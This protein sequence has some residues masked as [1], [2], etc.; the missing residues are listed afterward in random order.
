LKGLKRIYIE[1]AILFVSR[2][3]ETL[4]LVFYVN[5]FLTIIQTLQKILCISGLFNEQ[6][7]I[8][9]A[10]MLKM[11]K[12]SDFCLVLSEIMKKYKIQ[13]RP[14]KKTA[15]EF[16]EILCAFSHPCLLFSLGDELN[17]DYRSLVEI[18][19]ECCECKKFL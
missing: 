19:K 4:Q 18:R 1:Y 14:F 15:N 7:T 9:K 6:S 17:V 12:S 8:N 11:K 2:F 13:Q 3:E 16:S 5:L 10:Q